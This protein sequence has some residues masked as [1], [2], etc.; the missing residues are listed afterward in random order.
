LKELVADLKDCGVRYAMDIQRLYYDRGY[1]RMRATIDQTT[2][3]PA[4]TQAPDSSICQKEK[5]IF[6]HASDQGIGLESEHNMCV[7]SN[8]S[9]STTSNRLTLFSPTAQEQDTRK[10]DGSSI[11]AQTDP[12]PYNP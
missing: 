8:S 9:C 11:S 2:E 5:D 1:L 7:G 6:A 12:A 4:P 10:G 3:L